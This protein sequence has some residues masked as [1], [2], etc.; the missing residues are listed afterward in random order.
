M[1]VNLYFQLIERFEYIVSFCHTDV[2]LVSFLRVG[3]PLCA[4]SSMVT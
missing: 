4:S 3:H 2:M 1:L